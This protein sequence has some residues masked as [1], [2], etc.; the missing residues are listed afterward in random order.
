MQS[1]WHLEGAEKIVVFIIEEK[2]A[3]VNDCYVSTAS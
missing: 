2:T 1:M 3:R